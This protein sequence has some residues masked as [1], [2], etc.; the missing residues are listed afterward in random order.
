MDLINSVN[1]VEIPVADFERAKA[2]YQ[3]LFDYEM[4]ESQV[5]ETRM[6]FLPYRQEPERVGAAICQG[7]GYTPSSDGALVYLN[8]GDD[9]QQVLDRVEEA[10]G[11]VVLEKTLIME[12]VGYMAVFTDTEGNRVALHSRN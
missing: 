12:E 11:Q 2:F 7:E 6:G 10:G 9:L 3:Q 8:G 1:W 5:Q 4:I